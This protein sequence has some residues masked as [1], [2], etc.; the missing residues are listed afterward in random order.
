MTARTMLTRPSVPF[1]SGFVR[2]VAYH[3]VVRQRFAF[4]LV[5]EYR[6]RVLSPL[7]CTRLRETDQTLRHACFPA[8]RRGETL[9]SALVVVAEAV[10]TYSG[11]YGLESRVNG[12]P[13][14]RLT[15]CRTWAHWRGSAYAPR[16]SHILLFSFFRSTRCLRCVL[17]SAGALSVPSLAAERFA[18]STRQIA[19]L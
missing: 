12:Y 8:P 16:P 1:A 5:H 2:S 18:T 6:C 13:G 17:V 3:D 7:L 10:Q 11:T 19:F 4:F 14:K 9:N 15:R